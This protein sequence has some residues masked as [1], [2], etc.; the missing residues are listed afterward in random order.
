MP[1]TTNFIKTPFLRGSRADHGEAFLTCFA[2]RPNPGSRDQDELL[3]RQSEASLS[4]GLHA[5]DAALHLNRYRVHVPE[6]P[7]RRI[8]VLMFLAED[9]PESKPLCLPKSYPDV[10]VV[11]SRQDGDGYNEPGPLDCPT[12][13][14]VFAQLL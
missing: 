8:G 3:R 2:I 5:G 4:Y 11:Q 1:T 10:I 14:C 13:G 9:D 7:F 12:E 6:A